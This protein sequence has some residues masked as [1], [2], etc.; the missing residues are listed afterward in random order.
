VN[1]A[2]PALE[3]VTQDGDFGEGRIEMDAVLEGGADPFFVSP[4]Y[5]LDFLDKTGTEQVRFHLNGTLDPIRV[6]SIGD[7]DYTYIVMPMRGN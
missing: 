1:T 3:L 7:P 6:E 2:T 4:T 5:L